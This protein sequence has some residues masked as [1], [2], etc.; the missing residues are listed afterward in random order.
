M[1][2]SVP[3][4]DRQ[5]CARAVGRGYQHMRKCVRDRYRNTAAAG[6]DVEARPPCHLTVE[7]DRFFDDELCLGSGNEHV[8][9]DLEVEIPELTVADDLRDRFATD[10]AGNQL[11]ERGVEPRG[12]GSRP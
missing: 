5:R 6:P 11:V 7:V 2:A 4:R 9:V 3:S 12:E 10:P 8:G 1:T